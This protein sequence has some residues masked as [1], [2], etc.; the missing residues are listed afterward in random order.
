MDNQQHQNEAQERKKTEQ[1]SDEQLF[2]PWEQ[3]F[4][5]DF[6]KNEREFEF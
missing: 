2:D 5:C 6:Q 3:A 1:K 4:N